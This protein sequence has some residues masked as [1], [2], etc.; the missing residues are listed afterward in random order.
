MLRSSFFFTFYHKKK[1]LRV[2]RKQLLVLVFC[3]V[4]GYMG[5]NLTLFIAY[6]LLGAGLATAIHFSYPLFV[7]VFSVLLYK[8][9]LNPA[10]KTALLLS[11]GGV[12]LLS[13]NGCGV[14]DIQG[15]FFAIFSAVLYAFYV[16]GI[17]SRHLKELDSTVLTFY[18]CLF[19]CI[20][21]LV[22]GGVGRELGIGILP[23][24]GFSI[25]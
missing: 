15:I 6:Q 2:S 8:E 20:S 25:W 1:D 13:I 19:S 21:S 7:T 18:I 12:L 11:V 16:V 14:T 4:V 24:M 23:C 3:A 5:M 17:A 9:H 10:K 22:P